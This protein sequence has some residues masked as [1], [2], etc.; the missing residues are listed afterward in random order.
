ME[1]NP[2]ITN[3]GLP[4]SADVEAMTQSL[5][6][7]IL[8]AK[9]NDDKTRRAI[10]HDPSMID[11]IL[12]HKKEAALDAVRKQGIEVCGENF[13]QQQRDY[14]EFARILMRETFNNALIKLSVVGRAETVTGAA[15][16]YHQV[17]NKINEVINSC[18]AQNETFF[19]RAMERKPEY[20]RKVLQT[21]LVHRLE[22]FFKA[23]DNLTD[24]FS[25]YINN[26]LSNPTTLS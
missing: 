21:R 11:R 5:Q 16:V 6:E 10:Q 13:L 8:A 9:N 24:Y 26:L 17:E 1:T 14:G 18:A 22:E 15:A 12:H 2:I 19:Y 7:M 4:M 20:I 23:I 25:G 3:P